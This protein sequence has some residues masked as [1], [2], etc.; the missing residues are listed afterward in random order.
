MVQ[1]VLER[2]FLLVF[3]GEWEV[4]VFEVLVVSVALV[5]TKV[6]HVEVLGEVYLVSWCLAWEEELV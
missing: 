4:W 3:F 2:V 6:L 5:L 1:G